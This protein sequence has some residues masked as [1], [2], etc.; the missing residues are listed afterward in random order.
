MPFIFLKRTLFPRL[1]SVGDYK[2]TRSDAC[3]AQKKFIRPSRALKKKSGGPMGPLKKRGV[4]AL[5]RT[6]R[7][8]GL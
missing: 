6:P 1:P 3:L 8:V 5:E 2:K 4:L 7:T